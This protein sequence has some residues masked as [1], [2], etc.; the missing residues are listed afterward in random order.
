M[1]V[2]EKYGVDMVSSS[3]MHEGFG[4]ASCLAV[5]TVQKW[6]RSNTRN[7]KSRGIFIDNTYVSEKIMM[8]N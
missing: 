7:E 8:P 2:T 4:L 6:F 5:S 1:C 3:T